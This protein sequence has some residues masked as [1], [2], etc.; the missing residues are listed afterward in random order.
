[1]FS[2]FNFITKE[3]YK[4]TR[5]NKMQSFLKNPQKCNETEIE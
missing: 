3:N 5:T 2:C 4:K 1:M